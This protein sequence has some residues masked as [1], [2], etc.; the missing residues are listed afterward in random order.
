MAEVL[1]WQVRVSLGKTA[2]K[3]KEH[4]FNLCKGMAATHSALLGM[5][6]KALKTLQVRVR[7]QSYTGDFGL[8]ACTDLLLKKGPQK[9]PSFES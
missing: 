9:K 6:N 3:G 7:E 8:G 1:Q 5:S 4:G 2:W